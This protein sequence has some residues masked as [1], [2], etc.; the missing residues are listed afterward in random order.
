[1]N[2][3][4]ATLTQLDKAKEAL[5][6]LDR[7]LALNPG[8][9]DAHCNR[10]FALL[11]TDDE[12]KALI[13][14]KTAL[15]H[16]PEYAEAHV[17]IARVYRELH[18]LDDAETEIL[19]AIE[20]DPELAEAHSVMGSIL[21]SNGHSDKGKLA[22]NRALE[23][24][25]ESTSAQLGL[26][27]IKLEE[28]H[29]DEAEEIFRTVM[30]SEKETSSA[31]FNLVQSRKTKKGDP[32]VV[33]MEEEA[34]KLGEVSDGKA[35]YMNFAL[36]KMYDD[37]GESDKAFPH[38]IEGCR[39][40][41]KTLEY[42]SKQKEQNF[43]RIAEVFSKDFI[44]EHKGK[45]NKSKTPIFVLGMPR[46]GST[47]T[48]Q[49]ISSHPDVFGAGELFEM[50]E[51]AGQNSATGEF[52]FP[53]NMVDLTPD[54]IKAM[55]KEYL[56]NV[57]AKDPEAKKITDKMPANFSNIGLIHLILPK[58]K[59]VHIHRHPLDT[60]ISCF[61]RMFAY[62]QNQTYNLKELGLFY[63][64]Y[65]DLMKHWRTILPKG[66]IYDIR[67]EDLVEDTEGQARSLL[68]YCDLEWDDQ[69]LEFHKNKRSIR[70]ASV[71]QVRQPIY[72]TSLARW[73]KYE[74]FLYPLTEGL[75]D[76]LDGEK[77]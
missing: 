42:D 56:A 51:V 46:S 32:E 48:E 50:L 60:C 18:K 14:F 77:M 34:K 11:G 31:L 54:R 28:G 20:I 3:A 25:S 52:N 38:F 19:K 49:I 71:T 8:Y 1:M 55:G 37:L 58:A 9:A 40:K 62:N 30:A 76:A 75:G 22:F 39:L 23:I 35:T 26:G 17:G 21:V 65:N 63:K 61:T 2:N 66:S 15:H 10:G 12:G 6:I 44:K 68:E 73:K 4:G 67:Y 16:R 5:I 29:L 59:I 27:N 69:C 72:K 7:A 57:Q 41:R 70:T 36:G 53:E 64:G 43:K 24:D 47:L 45:G 74:K 33:L 13:S